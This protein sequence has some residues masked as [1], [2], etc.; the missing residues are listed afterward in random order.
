LF[1]W[2]YDSLTDLAK[3]QEGEFKS[4]INPGFKHVYQLIQVDDYMGRGETQPVPHFFQNLGEAEYVVA[5]YMYMRLLGYPASKITILSTYNG[6]RELIQDVLKR[7]C[8]HH[9]LFGP[10]GA[11]ATVDKYQGQQ[12]DCE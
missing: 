7:R 3:V 5:V 12:N 9:P 1:G 8:N 6:Q 10:P 2:R 4:G 11:L